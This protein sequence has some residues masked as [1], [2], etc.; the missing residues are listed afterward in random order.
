MSL[1]HLHHRVHYNN[2][3]ALVTCTVHYSRQF[4]SLPGLSLLICLLGSKRYTFSVFHFEA[5]NCDDVRHRF[6]RTHMTFLM[7][8]SSTR[9]GVITFSTLS[10]RCTSRKPLPN[11]ADSTEAICF[12]FIIFNPPKLPPH[13]ASHLIYHKMFFQRD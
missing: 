1:V 7:H 13:P 12:C 5:I 11:T 6:T 10:L 8:I 9:D 3:T 2:E 4:I